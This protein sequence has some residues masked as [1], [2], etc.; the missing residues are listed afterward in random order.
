MPPAALASAAPADPP[1]YSKKPDWHET[2]LAARDALAAGEAQG[3]GGTR[4]DAWI[5][6]VIRGGEKAVHVSLP[7]GGRKEL[8][9][10]VVGA[11]EVIG[12]CATWADAKLI[13]RGGTE[14]RL[15]HLKSAKILA[16][17]HSIDV[18]LE[19]GV[20]GPLK[21]AGR[22]FDHGIHVYAPARI[23]VPLDDAA[24][25]F[26][27][28][29]GIDDWVGDR[30]AVRFIVT[31]PEG[32]ARLE[33][34]DLAARDFTTGVPRREM[35]WERE[36]LI[37]GADWPRGDYAALAKRYAE[38]AKRIP[39]LAEQAARLAPA[40]RDAAGLADVRKLYQRSRAL[41]EALARGRTL[42]VRALRMAITDLAQTFEAT[43]PGGDKYLARLA[44]I[45]KSVAEALA[46]AEK[47][48]LA[49]AERVEALVA[50][51]DRL[52]REALLASPLLDFDRLVLIQRKPDGDARRPDGTGYGL[53][54]YIGLP[55]QS[56]K[57]NPGI[58]RPFDWDNEIAV[59][60]PVRPEGRL[61]ALYKP[62][63]RR[64]V[65]DLEPHWDGDRLLFSMPG[66]HRKWQVFEIG[67]DGKGLRQVTPGDQPDVDNYD[68]CYLPNGQ[69]AFLSTACLQGVPCNAGVIVGMLYKM[70]ADGSNIRQLAF[71]QDHDYCPTVMNDGRILYLRWDYTDTP[72]V[73]N[74][75]LFTMNPDGTGQA[76]Y[77]KAN[78]YWPNS[79]FYARPIPGDPTKVVGIATGHHVGRTGELVIFDP[80]RG[81]RDVEG[82]VQ[83]LPGYGQK[84]EPVIRD[85]LTEF[86]WPKFLHPWPLSEKHF[87]VAAKPAPDALWGI[88]LVDIYDNMVLVKEA[89]GEALLEPVPV[90]KTPRPPVVVPRSDPARKD[91]IIYVSDVYEGPSMQGIPR[92]TVKAL[93][94]FTYHFGYHQIAGIDH[95]VGA[96]GPWEVKRILGTVRVEDDGSALF[97]VPA[98]TPLSV[99]PLDAEGR[100]V[101]LMRSWMTA[102]PGENV[103]CVGCHDNRG[104]APPPRATAALTHPPQELQP[105]YGP[106]RGFSFKRE[107]QPVLDRFCVGCHD[108]KARPDGQTIVDLRGEQGAYVVYRGGDPKGQVVRDT[109]REQLL[110][111]Y[112]GIFDPSYIALRRYVRVGGLESD[113]R[114]LKPMEF[115][116][117]TS[118]LF[119]MLRK[120]H[121]GVALE[122]EAWERL[123][124]WIDLN[125]PCHGTW[126]ELTPLVGR[127]S[128][129]RRELQ[130][131]YGGVDE[132]QEEVPPGTL[133]HV[134]PVV[135]PAALEARVAPVACEGWP[136]DAG[137]ARRRQGGEGPPTR[138]VDLG[139]GA[140]LEFVRVPAGRFVM[141][142]AAGCPDER[143]QTLVAIDKP[144]W[145]G[146]FEVT[147]AEFARF[148]PSHDSRFEHRS[149]WIF[150][151]KYLGWPL[152]GP[153]QPVVRVS[154]NEAV[155][156]CRWLSGK[157]G[158]AVALP[159]EAQWE[160]ACRAGTAGPLSYGGLD[161]DFSRF[162]NLA[163]VTI[164]NLA[165]EGWSP[166]SPDLAPRD[167]R[168]DDHALVTADVGSYEANPW[169]LSDMHGNAAEWTRTAYRPYPYREDDGHNDLR[170]DGEKVVRG[171]S[172][173]DRPLR[174]RS[175]FRL[176]YPAYQAVFNVGFRV[177]FEE[178]SGGRRGD[179]GRS[180][181]FEP[182]A[183][184]AGD[185]E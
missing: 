14:T 139:G 66:S 91:A 114:L 26:E 36:D 6:P 137:E 38:A 49:G 158:L 157:A 3:Q 126:R 79:I 175:A 180:R 152:N 7:I 75:M 112:G 145:M 30:G 11:P 31:G 82:V 17:Q 149:S 18:T 185:I 28:D 168:F 167:A 134:E 33:L 148:D 93:R 59:L 135:P 1:Y 23:V 178:T 161:A 54:E 50:D 160:Y 86:S 128:E 55:R 142:D 74:R 35:K 150:S 83:R 113:L 73:W 60:S 71:E 154:W 77:Y 123:G 46:L 44:T 136:F 92:G 164:R 8:D 9:L 62:A 169:G 153:R 80:T 25:R 40:A 32:A 151:E 155:A 127:Q 70:N 61:T 130:R 159:T 165:Y 29:I 65:L 72:H 133:A 64:L 116:A 172:W 143:P 176:S 156:F 118:E 162:A 119:Q 24:E 45:E 125:A 174:C 39:A 20:S 43:Y 21:I 13:G 107:V 69:V 106:P 87:L 104:A 122:R 105:W 56:S 115:H 27:A 108:G 5:S 34:W 99:Q 2:L 163:D 48:G 110:G 78:S 177:V 4:L 16:P 144:F 166:K 146:R 22:K 10:F 52:Q 63:D 15:C 131:L 111:K 120:G 102:M 141:G 132:D 51:F 68:A 42:G 124:A 47:G 53:G 85:K 129:R 97:R 109:P 12:G 100:A 89:E 117:G 182:A 140:K 41:D 81:R 67:T 138:S 184:A 94:V 88:Y 173:Y 179:R 76:E 98:K 84:V 96:D 57:H 121:H 101:Q 19:S 37:L 147:N 58:D 183:E 90:R 95:R 171:G 181:K 103:T 170:A